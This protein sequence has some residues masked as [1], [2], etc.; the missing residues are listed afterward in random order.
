MS[1][2]EKLKSGLTKTRNNIF[3]AVR[4]DKLS[5]EYFERVEEALVLGDAGMDVAMSVLDELRDAV[6]DENAADEAAANAILKR[7]CAERLRAETELDLG[8]KPAV[9]LLIGV[10]G[11]G[12][13]TACGKLAAHYL[14]EGRRVMVAAADTFRAAAVE[15]LQVWAERSGA[16]FI[17]GQKDPAAVVYD[18]VA[19]AASGKADI[20]ICDTA[21]RLQTKKNLMEELA[22]ISRTVKKAAPD[23][24]V[25][26]LLVLDG[27]TGQNAIEQA[28]A[29]ADAAE[30]SGIIITKLD[31]T[32]KGGSVFAVK[33]KLGIPVRFIGVGEGIDDLLVFEPEAFCEAMFG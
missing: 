1:F 2:F 16:A 20:V 4:S 10:N 24:S 32:A 17:S 12:K 3:Y 30:V 27:M 8:G 14:A 13:T 31:G 29:F 15:Q 18:A 28:R 7:I 9:I 6:R 23:A 26:T 11:A 19:S 5:E 21:G 22:K 25:E 33:Q